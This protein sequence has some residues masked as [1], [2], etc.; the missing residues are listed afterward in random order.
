MRTQGFMLIIVQRDATIY[1]I[2][3]AANCSTYFGWWHHPSSWAHIESLYP[4]TIVGGSSSVTT[5]SC[6]ML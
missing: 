5:T 6:Q 3:I 4:S 2:F 1:S